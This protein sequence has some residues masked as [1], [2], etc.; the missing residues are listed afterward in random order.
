MLQNHL[1]TSQSITSS[2]ETE[3]TIDVGV[4][5]GQSARKRE[6]KGPYT[7]KDRAHDWARGGEGGGG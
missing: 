4:T 5:G 2:K 6:E 3:A 7:K 1:A